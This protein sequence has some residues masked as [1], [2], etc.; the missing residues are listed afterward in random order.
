MIATLRSLAKNWPFALAMAER[1]LKGLNKGAVFGIGWLVVR[2]LI[3]VG[4][5]VGIVTYVFGARLGPDSGPFDYALFVL[6]GMFVWQI[7]QRALENSTSLIRDRIDTLK[8]VVYPVETL[9]VSAALVGLIGP[10]IV[11]AI[12]VVLAAILGR[13]P[14]TAVLLP[15]PFALLIALM[16]GV[17]W[18]FM[19]AGVIL[20][21]LREIVSVLMNLAI[22]VSPVLLSKTMVP[23]A[24]WEI[25]LLN[26]LS[27]PVLAFRD[28][29]QGEFHPVSWGIFAVMALASFT[30]GAWVIT[31]TKVMINEYI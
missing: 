8:Q 4:A 10:A 27:H 18:I 2:P 30:V 7:M 28:V 13:L 19:V 11:L 29:L 1:E 22:Y 12:Y 24:L 16:L 9:P 26:P 25:V 31:R 15:L 5:Y 6:P 23:A 21:D 14:W 20:K 17:T 3:Q